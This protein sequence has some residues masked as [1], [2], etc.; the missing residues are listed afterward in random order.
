MDD[1]S[2]AIPDE[3]LIDPETGLKLTAEQIADLHKNSYYPDEY[4]EDEILDRIVELST[5][6]SALSEKANALAQMASEL[7]ESY[8][9]KQPS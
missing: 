7:L 4:P 3:E 6:A 1:S 8:S 9:H 2:Y 5:E